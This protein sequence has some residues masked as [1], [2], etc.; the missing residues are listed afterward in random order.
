MSLE[1]SWYSGARWPL[2]LWPL[3]SVFKAIARS[4]KKKLLS[5]QWTSPVPLI[6]VGNISVGGTGKSPLT[7]HLIELLREKG[8]KPGVVSRGYGAQPVS[9]PFQ[10]S[11]DSS[12]VDSG[13]EPLMIVHRTG[14][15][16]VI[17][18]DR[19]AACRFLLEHN[20]CD[21]ILSD[22]GLQHYQMSRDIEL[23]VIDAAR[24]IGNGHCLPVGPLREP[25]TRLESV[26]FVL[27]NGD[28]EYEYPGAFSMSLIPTRLIRIGDGQEVDW[29]DVGNKVQAVA[30]IGNP[31][32]FFQTLRSQGLEVS[33]HAFKDHHRFNQD[34]FTFNDTLP[35]I[36]TEKDAVKCAN[37]SLPANC[38][39]LEVGVEL[40]DG[41]EEALL[42]RLQEIT[43]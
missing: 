39:Y 8:Y 16:F 43:K 1:Q 24:G 15:P 32:R 3:E 36:M 5:S 37:L 33:E 38:Y 22:D 25:E 14:V 35:V 23:A 2:L 18:P 28:G 34:D 19:P 17:D 29:D 13:D 42:K 10:V 21:I 31:W 7:I 20:D 30:G 6:V 41:F 11:P 27:I 4:R 12:T 26:D 9:F 40:A